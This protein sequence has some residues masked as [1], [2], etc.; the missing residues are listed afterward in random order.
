MF[1]S[2]MNSVPGMKD[3]PL[4]ESQS[5]G[6]RWIKHTEMMND[7]RFFLTLRERSF[8][9]SEQKTRTEK[10]SL[11]VEVEV[12]RIMAR[13]NFHHHRSGC[14]GKRQN[15]PYCRFTFMRCPS[16]CHQLLLVDENGHASTNI[17]PP[18]DFVDSNIPIR[19]ID[20]RPLV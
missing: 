14:R 17:P 7:C 1:C 9:Q 20:T 11:L 18:P 16:S 6:G 2:V 19:P 12:G 3:G 5:I 4:L 8:L 10:Q 15:D 13:C